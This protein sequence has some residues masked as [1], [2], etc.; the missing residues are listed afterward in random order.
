MRPGIR[1]KEDRPQEARKAME[2]GGGE[3]I[4]E[5]GA[6]VTIQSFYEFHTYENIINHFRNIFVPGFPLTFHF[7]LQHR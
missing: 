3:F 2:T 5:T 6:K 4:G 7:L 1:E